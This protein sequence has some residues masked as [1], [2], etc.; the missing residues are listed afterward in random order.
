MLA[1]ILLSFLLILCAIAAMAVG[2]L[3]GNR[4]IRGSCGGV[5][6]EGCELCGSAPPAARPHDARTGG[7]S[8]D[9]RRRV[10]HRNQP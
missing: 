7:F 9:S 3:F 5:G 4:S 10:C 6:S 1:T 8:V 2:V